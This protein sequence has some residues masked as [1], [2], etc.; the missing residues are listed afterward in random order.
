MQITIQARDFTLTNALRSHIER[1]LR[2][3]LTQ[4]D[5]HIQ[6]VSV[7]LSDINGPRGGADKRCHILVSLKQVSDIAIKDTAIDL[8]DAINRAARRVGRTV[9]RRI[10]RR[11]MLHRL[12]NLPNYEEPAASHII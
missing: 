9:S 5:D 10:A 3:A 7:R 6:R 12:G 8:Y 2:L 1:R 11:R 4:H